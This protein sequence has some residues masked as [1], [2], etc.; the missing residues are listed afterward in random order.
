MT[1]FTERNR[2]NAQHSTGPRTP[3]GKAISSQNARKHGF[4]VTTY[5]LL[6]NE[7]PEEYAAFEAEILDAYEPKSNRERLAAIDIAKA[8]WALRRFDEAEFVLLNACLS[9]PH[10][11]PGETLAYACITDPTK[12]QGTDL[13]SLDLLLRYRRPWDRRHQEAIR[14]FDRARADRYREERLAMQKEREALKQQMQAEKPRK[15]TRAEREAREM[16]H[17]EILLG[18]RK[19]DAEPAPGFVSPLDMPKVKAAAV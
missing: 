10:Q 1:P 11:T 14:E 13:P 17:V 5:H 3:E 2:R 6:S 9:N 19:P 16:R 15:E 12:P 4:S 7:D 18:F 8:R